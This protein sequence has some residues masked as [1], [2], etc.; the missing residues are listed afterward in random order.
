MVTELC[1]VPVV[2]KRG[3]QTLESELERTVPHAGVE[4]GLARRRVVMVTCV[5]RKR[6]T[7]LALNIVWC[8]RSGNGERLFRRRGFFLK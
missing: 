3:S 1:T 4:T 8:I 5:R 7:W 6:L 2:C